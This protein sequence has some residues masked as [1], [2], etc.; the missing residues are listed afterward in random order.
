MVF[1]KREIPSQT[2]NRV[3]SAV[4]LGYKKNNRHKTHSE[5]REF[6][7]LHLIQSNLISSAI[8]RESFGETTVRRIP[9]NRGQH[10]GNG[11]AWPRN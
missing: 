10:T 7:V 1:Q 11:N 4:C 9:Q 6:P 2:Q 5:K 3:Q 8:S